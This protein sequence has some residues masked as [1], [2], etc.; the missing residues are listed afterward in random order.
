MGHLSPARV[1]RG[2]WR[3]RRADRPSSARAGHQCG[4]M[5]LAS[6]GHTIMQ[7]LR[8]SDLRCRWGGEEFLVVLP[9]SGL[10]Q[11]RRVAVALA[12][13]IAT[14]VT[15]YDSARIQLTTSVGVTIA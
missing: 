8:V 3:H 7:T 1:R 12:R 4:D 15:E 13:R 9:E 2:R 11:A 14:T 6:I 5:V 10:D